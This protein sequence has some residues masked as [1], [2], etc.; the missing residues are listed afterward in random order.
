MG[1]VWQVLTT[2]NLLVNY[3]GVSTPHEQLNRVFFALS[4]A[5]RR[6]I[7]AQLASGTSTVGD[8]ARP[9]NMSAPAISRHLRILEKA[10]LIR[11]DKRGREHHCSLSTD[12]LQTA[13]DWL[14]FHRDFWESRLNALED[15]ISS[16]D[17]DN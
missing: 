2:L 17:T 10:G 16:E 1:E 4:D 11:R 15:F 7:L 12:G 6:G 5:T 8:L 3:R 9:Y 14:N 13:E